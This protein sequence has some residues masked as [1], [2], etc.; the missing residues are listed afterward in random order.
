M[1]KL[2]KVCDFMNVS[3]ISKGLH[4]PRSFRKFER[5]QPDPEQPSI[6]TDLKGSSGPVE[7]GYASYYPPGAKAFVKACTNVNIPHS[8]DFN[9]QKGSKGVNRVSLSTYLLI[10]KLTHSGSCQISM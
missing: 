8:D 7:V 2:P 10:S 4:E 3:D 6:N 9:T 1:E 5:Y